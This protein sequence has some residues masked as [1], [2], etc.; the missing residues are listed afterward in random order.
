MKIWLQGYG[1]PTGVIKTAIYY[2]YDV[3]RGDPIAILQQNTP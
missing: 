3:C 2:I 1:I